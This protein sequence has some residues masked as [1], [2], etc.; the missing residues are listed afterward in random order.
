[1]YS[2][3]VHSALHSKTP[4]IRPESLTVAGHWLE[5]LLH[6]A[7]QAGVE[8][9]DELARLG[10]SREQL[11]TPHCR[12]PL[13]AEQALLQAALTRSNDPCFGLHMGTQVRPR[14]LGAL[15]YAAMSSATLRQAMALALPFQRVTHELLV[16]DVERPPGQLAIIWQLQ[17]PPSALDPQRLEIFSAASITFGR[18][19]TGAVVNPLQVT[20]R[21]RP[22]G[23]PAE[24]EQAFQCPVVFGAERDSVLL[25]DAVLDLPVRDADPE[26]HRIMRTR[27]HQVMTRFMARDNLIG[28]VRSAIQRQL[29]DGT[30]QLDS[31]AASLGMKPWT[32]RRRLR[33]E[34]ADFTTLL[35]DERKT[36]ATDWL[37][38][39]N[40]PVSQIATDLGYSEQSAVN[41]AFRRWFDCT[42]VSWREQQRL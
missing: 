21:H 3:A 40:R 5:F 14:F 33:A 26:V 7:G 35:D 4:A 23:D 6:A 36:L 9:D 13:Q 31:V 24:Y 15:G 38:H 19:I 34:G 30:A 37:L 2:N 8:L 39:S 17:G 41:R 18:W 28:Q 22:A 42:P 1:M 11:A 32:L 20:F 16:P 12:A 29:L 10:L 25:D 27:V